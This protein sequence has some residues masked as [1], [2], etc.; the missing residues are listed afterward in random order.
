M[1]RR[2]SGAKIAPKKKVA[3]KKK[4]YVKMVTPAGR[5]AYPYL[6]TINDGGQYPTHTYQ[7]DILIPK[8]EFKTKQGKA[9]INHVLEIASKTFD[10]EFESLDEIPQSPFT[11]MDEKDNAQDFEKG[12]Y[13]I[14]AKVSRGKDNNPRPPFVWDAQKNVLSDDDVE[15]IKGGDYGRL[16]VS[17]WGYT[18]GDGGVAFNL[19]GVQFWKTGEAIGGS[20]ASNV[21]LLDE[22][23]VPM[24]D[25]TEE[26]EGHT[27]H[28]EDVNF[29]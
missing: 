20:A 16:I 12:C 8:S 5:L 28:G 25:P 1:T 10:E 9:L 14:R 24:E 6:R 13:R 23:E 7:T 11:D 4:E 19:D 21:S 17:G 3:A 2:T 27:E 15:A 29:D 18:K 22:M 26:E